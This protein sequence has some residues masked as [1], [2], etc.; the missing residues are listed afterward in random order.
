MH[1]WC[2]RRVSAASGRRAGRRVRWRGGS[3]GRAGQILGAVYTR[4]SR[5]V[6]MD[7][8]RYT[9]EALGRV[10]RKP[11]AAAVALLTA[12]VRGVDPSAD[13]RR[14]AVERDRE[15]DEHGWEEAS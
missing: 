7:E 10:V 15:R 12:A 3:S 13:E 2:S 9:P 11:R 14:R 6:L 4:A 5:P 8:D 1:G